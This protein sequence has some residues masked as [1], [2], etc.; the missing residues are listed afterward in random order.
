VPA[1]LRFV[2]HKASGLAYDDLPYGESIPMGP[3]ANIPDCPF[4]EVKRQQPDEINNRCPHIGRAEMTT[5]L[6][7]R[8]SDEIQGDI[9]AG[10]K[11]DH[12]CF[13]L[14]Q[15]ENADRAREWLGVVKDQLSYTRAVAKFNRDFS[16][17]RK[18]QGADPPDMKSC[19]LGLTLT[20]S[21]MALVAPTIVS[22]FSFE[23]REGPARRASILGDTGDDDP[24]GWEFGGPNTKRVDAILT[25]ACDDAKQLEQAKQRHLDSYKSY[26]IC[27]VYMEE[28]NAIPV[29]K[30]KPGSRDHF[31]FRD[32]FFQP[33]VRDFDFPD[34]SGTAVNDHPA[35]ELIAAGEF[36]LGQVEESPPLERGSLRVRGADELSNGSYQVFRRLH[37]DVVR[38]NEQVGN[39]V[40]THGGVGSDITG[41]LFMSKLIGR[42]TNGV[43]ASHNASGIS[44]SAPI[45][46]IDPVYETAF[47]FSADQ[48]GTTTP[49]FAHIRRMRT[50]VGAA[51]DQRMR[52][53]LRRS[54][55]YGPVF[56][57][58]IEQSEK[59]PRGLY[60]I[61]YMTSI[62]NQFEWLQ[63]KW[64]S[65]R[66]REA[67]GVDPLIGTGPEGHTLHH[68]ATDYQFDFARCVHTTGALY[69]F[70]PS[71]TLLGKIAARTFA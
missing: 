25:I 23:F 45:P 15:F 60:F 50:G 38:W 4:T 47:D 48:E 30:D 52:R 34:Q 20:A 44:G 7:L 13:H 8:D 40:A 36:V 65:N 59:K 5:E 62:Y 64:A 9:L 6:P 14:L 2:L 28:A 26:G 54:I 10:F 58:G 71:R 31:G 27:D 19:W 29:G 55:P 17:T 21:G 56:E 49:L 33:G 41:E 63:T 70:A 35:R 22:K 37:Q 57:A 16:E 66:H 46:K 18:R 61:A 43:A 11:K 39:F 53:I 68:G 42:W 3:D 51:A 24:D 12:C 69:G 32:G 1:R 67:D